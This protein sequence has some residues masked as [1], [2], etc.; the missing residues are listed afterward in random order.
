[1]K[2][3]NVLEPSISKESMAKK[4]EAIEIASFWARIGAIISAPF[5]GIN[6]AIVAMKLSMVIQL[7]HKSVLFN[8]TFGPYLNY[9]LVA[10]SEVIQ[11]AENKDKP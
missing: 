8:T 4:Y 5:L 7:F 11:S 10:S 1:M 2:L 3:Q 9:F 6:L